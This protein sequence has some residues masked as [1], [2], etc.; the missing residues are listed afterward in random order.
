MAGATE[1][2]QMG[3]ETA[4]AT[5]TGLI[6]LGGVLAGMVVLWHQHLTHR[7]HLQ[8]AVQD[9]RRMHRLTTRLAGCVVELEQ[10]LSAGLPSAGSGHLPEPVAG[11]MTYL[12]GLRDELDVIG[13]HA[14]SHNARIGWAQT[15]LERASATARRCTASQS[16]LDEAA[17]ALSGAARAYEEGF[18]AAYSKRRIGAAVRAPADPLL[19]LSEKR[20]K[21]IS[22]KRVT[23]DEQMRL[24]ATHI[25][26]RHPALRH[27]KTTWPIWT[28]ELGAF[29][30]DPYRGE[31]RPI[32]HDGFGPVP[33]LHPD[34]R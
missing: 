9:H 13:S 15:F 16:A 18:V 4:V 10:M 5:V 31:I 28:S 14:A 24:L 21:D 12:F 25:N 20:A 1:E 26:V 19:M 8:Q 23:F 30:G 2:M 3:L 32:G 11:H 17:D 33:V 6:A 27:Y 29:D 7:A 34:A 22:R